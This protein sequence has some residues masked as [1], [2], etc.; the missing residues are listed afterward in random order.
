MSAKQSGWLHN[1]WTDAGTCV[2]CTNTC[3]RHQPL[4]PATWSSASLIHGQAY[5]KTPSTKHLVNGKTGYM[6]ACKWHHF[7]Q[8]RRSCWSMEKAVV[9]K[10]EGKRTSLW[11]S[12]KLKLAL[13]RANTYTTGFFQSHQQSTEKNVVSRHYH[14]S[15]L[16]ANKVSK[17]ITKVGYACQFWKCADAVDRKLSKLIHACR[18]YS[19]VG[20]FFC[21][22]VYY[23]ICFTFHQT[24]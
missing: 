6:Q 12:A 2:H 13:F 21:D 4:W 20:V 5:H 10:R 7:E 8:K 11:T 17:R 18:K 9:C 23:T 22:T 1:L 16:K 24:R 15:Y 3:P 14:R 19:K